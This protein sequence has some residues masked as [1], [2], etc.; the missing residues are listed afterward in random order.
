MLQYVILCYKKFIMPVSSFRK[1]TALVKAAQTKNTKLVYDFDFLT[2][3]LISDIKQ[4]SKS[5]LS[6]YVFSIS[7]DELRHAIK[8]HG[9]NS[10]DKNPLK[11]E[12]FYLIT[13]IIKYYDDIK[14]GSVSHTHRLKTIKFIKNICTSYCIVLEIRTIRKRLSFLTMYKTKSP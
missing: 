14:C 5:N 3:K 1:I 8:R 12:D 9:V 11:W 4:K 10:S 13:L 2:A 7:A 6:G